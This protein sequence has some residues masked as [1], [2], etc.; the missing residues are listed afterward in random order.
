LLRTGALPALL[1][2]RRENADTG[3]VPSALQYSLTQLLDRLKFVCQAD[4]SASSSSEPP[5]RCHI[6]SFTGGPEAITLLTTEPAAVGYVSYVCWH[7][8]ALRSQCQLAC[9]CAHA[10][11]A[12]RS[13][14]KVL[15]PLRG[16]LVLPV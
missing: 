10:C 13:G 15:F 11:I 14:D 7:L 9:V 8:L 6:S 12:V 3:V 4:M 1:A 16:W 2:R 5:N